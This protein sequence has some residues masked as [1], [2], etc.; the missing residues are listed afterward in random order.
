MKMG[1]NNVRFKLLR[2]TVGAAAALFLL[3]TAQAQTTPPPSLL[4]TNSNFIAGSDLAVPGLT[5]VYFGGNLEWPSLAEDGTVLFRSNLYGTGTAPG[6]RYA[7]FMGT[8][9]TNLS[10]LARW[11]DPAPGLPGLSLVSGNL[12][13]GIGGACSLSPSGGYTFWNSYLS[14]AGVNGNND[15]GQFGSSPSGGFL[16]N[17][18]GDPAPGTPGCFFSGDQIPYGPSQQ[19]MQVNRHGAVLFAS[20]L[21]GGDVTGSTNNA[22]LFTGTPGALTMIARRG[23]TVLPGP[24][25]ITDLAQYILQMDNDGRVLYDVVLG[26]PGA[27]AASDRSVWYYTPG[28][29]SKLLVREGDPAPGTAGAT[30]NNPDNSQWFVNVSQY[31][32]TRSGL[33][34]FTADLMG[35]DVTPGINDNAFYI[36]SP[37]NGLT[38]V[39]RKGDPAPGTDAFFWGFNYNYAYVNDSGKVA[40]QCILT[41]GTSTDTNKDGIWTGTPGNLHL[42]VRAGDPAPGTAGAT[43]Q[44]FNGWLMSFNDLGQILITG[45]LTG[46]DVIQGFNDNGVWAYDPVRGLFLVARAGENY[47]F[48]PDDFRTTSAFAWLQFSNTDGNALGFGKNGT[49]GMRVF[50]TDGQAIATVNLNCYPPT[51]YYFDGDGDGYGDANGTPL[52]V[53]ANAA[54]PAGYVANNTDCNDSDPTIHPGAPEICNGIDD[55]CDGLIDNGVVPPGVLTSVTMVKHPGGSADLNWPALAGADTYD[56]IRGNLG[57]LRSSHGDFSTS[58]DACVANDT[59]ATSITDGTVPSS[60]AGLWYLVR[61]SNNCGGVGTYDDPPGSKSASRDAGIAASPNACP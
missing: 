17:R 46:G 35:G 5:D 21:G 51:N 13:Q 49:I 29:G 12:A 61:G 26:G 60:G 6:N 14:G 37:S 50:T 4:I 22:G 23:D 7:L 47:Q 10:V 32:L 19:F 53:C 3:S 44:P 36:G 59:P 30:F 56:A 34:S 9:A 11:S 40:F 41:G 43:F 2:I 57:T 42:V 38:M 18:E 33:Y 58:T 1:V 16:V 48:A 25:T 39:A 28:S 20:L 31:T 54:P 27:T 15:T 24:T 45:N 8:S 52:S 55:N